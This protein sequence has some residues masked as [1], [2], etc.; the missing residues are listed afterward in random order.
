MLLSKSWWTSLVMGSWSERNWRAF[1]NRVGGF[2]SLRNHLQMADGSI[3]NSNAMND[4]GQ[5]LAELAVS[6]QKHQPNLYLKRY[7]ESERIA[8]VYYWFYGR[9][10]RVVDGDAPYVNAERPEFARQ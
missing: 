2:R 5:S 8:R 1:F 9:I 4:D 10:P 7:R 3:F 6:L